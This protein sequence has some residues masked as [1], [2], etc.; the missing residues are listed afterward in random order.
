MKVLI[1]EDE[2][3]FQVFL[4]ERLRFC[5]HDVTL[6]ADAE[7]AW[8]ICQ[9][10]FYPLIIS[11]LGLP[12]MDGLE[13]CRRI[14]TLPQG[15]QCVILVI[16]ARDAPEDLQA[17]LDAGADDYL[18]KPVSRDLLNVR[19]TIIERQVR[20][21]AQHSQVEQE[22]RSLEMQLR[23]AQRIE[24]IGILAG[25][26]AHDFNNILGTMLGYTELLLNEYPKNNKEKEYLEQVYQAGE[27]AAELVQQILTFSRAQEQ[28][29]Q[30][31]FVAPIIEEALKMIRATI[32]A[33]VAIQQNIQQSCRPI[34]ADATQIHQVVVNL[35]V[36]ASYAMREQGGVLEVRLEDVNYDTDQEHILGLTAGSYLKLTVS[37]TGCG[38]AAEV[39]EYI[40][41]PFFTT[42]A[43]N[44]GTGLGLSVVHGIV[45]AHQ[46]VIAVNSAPGKGTT[47]RIFFPVAEQ[48]GSQTTMARADQ[49]GDGQE[50]ILIVEN[51]PSLAKLYEIALTRF[52]YHVTVCHD[53]YDALETF[54]INPTTFDLVFTDQAMPNMTGSQLTQ[55]LLSIR[56]DTPVILTTGHSDTLSEEEAHAL[57]IRRFLRKPVKVGT[58]IQTIQEIFAT[59]RHET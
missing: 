42:K 26:I 1:V 51:E 15:D 43:V 37:D 46:G 28:Y 53:G 29:L 21:R 14:R 38:M 25:G 12:G 10:T 20:H 9:Q 30:P 59:K 24:A 31:V 3:T 55:E 2:L 49:I 23:Q 17:V 52:E 56:A 33:T 54:R 35:C 45:K 50:S 36:N 58:L 22:R 8:D 47:F 7:T 4:G 44:E 32:P 57:G 41:E 27:R 19:L 16:T 18:L 34:L 5:G 39:Q 11:D 6:C 40:F 48:A 13:F